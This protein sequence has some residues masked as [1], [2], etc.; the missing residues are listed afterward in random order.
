[1]KP[2]MHVLV[3][4]WTRACSRLRQ[5]ESAAPNRTICSPARRVPS[6]CPR[7]DTP[8]VIRA[9]LLQSTLILLPAEEKVATVFGGDTVD[10]V[11]DGGHVASRFISVKPKLANSDDGHPHRLRPRQRVHPSAPRGLER[12]RRALRFQGVHRRPATRP[13]KD[14]TARTAGLRARRGAGQGQAGGSSRQSSAGR[15][16]EGR[17]GQGRDSTGA[18]IPATCTS[19]TP[20]TRRRARLL[21]CSRYGVTTS[22]PTCAASSRRRLRSTS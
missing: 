6:P 12:R 3:Y 20:G 7:P 11:F 8:P 13:A 10:W 18:S 16:A 21:A 17:G 5:R 4:L 14:K 19:T 9:G 2:P 22:S 1:M 15:G